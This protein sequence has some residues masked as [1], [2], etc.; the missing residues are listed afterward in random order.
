MTP[1]A[2]SR[3]RPRRNG[4]LAVHSI[5]EF[6]LEVPDLAPAEHFYR[7]F[8]L[9]VAGEG[10]Q[11]VLRTAGDGYPWGRLVAG[12]RKRLHHV[13]FHCYEEDLLPL[14]A[15][16]EGSGIR[17]LDASRGFESNGL[18][19]R[20]PFGALVEVRVGPKTSPDAKSREPVV[21][22]GPA[23]RGAPFRG[24]AKPT[25]PRRL[26]H[27]ALFAPNIGQAIDFYT[28]MLGLRLSD[29]SGD[30][31][32]FLH[33]AHGSDHHLVALALSGGPGLHH[34]SWDVPSIDAIGLGA[35]SLA[36]KGYR[37]GW[38]VG[39]HVIGSNWFYYAR[40]PWGSYSEYSCGIDYVPADME[41]PAADR[42]MEDGFYLWGP[43]VPQDFALNTELA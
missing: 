18:W 14:K 12:K 23:E 13:S 27:V 21:V 10:N 3:P 22:V 41:W 37:Q 9:D 25:V 33:G 39:R 17:L 28:R 42:P 26:S 31:V 19:F 6:A 16:L 35:M 5:G 38:G 24:D 29:R 11:L 2:T 8:G 4:A 32:A 30:V 40:D 15:R 43:E 20:D 36:E 34:V 7:S 1:D